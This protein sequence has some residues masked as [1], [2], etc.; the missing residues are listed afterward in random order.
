ML[1]NSD[2]FFLKGIGKQSAIRMAEEGATVWAT[3]IRFKKIFE[4][5]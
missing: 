3:D 1:D 2:D 4:K 5:K